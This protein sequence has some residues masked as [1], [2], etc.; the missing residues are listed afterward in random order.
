MRAVRGV[1]RKVVK[2]L[3][4]ELPQTFAAE[5]HFRPHEAHS[6]MDGHL[7]QSDPQLP[8]EFLSEGEQQ[9]RHSTHRD[10]H[11]P[12]EIDLWRTI[13]HYLAGTPLFSFCL[14]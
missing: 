3:S 2:L 6:C 9:G 8:L 11:L 13:E 5:V 1:S 12:Q 4:D 14:V 10:F 7:V